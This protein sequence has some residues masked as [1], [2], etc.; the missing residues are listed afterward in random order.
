MWSLERPWPPAPRPLLADTPV[1][2]LGALAASL[3]IA[4]LLTRLAALPPAAVG[5]VGIAAG[6]GAL[7]ATALTWDGATDPRPRA[8]LPPG[9]LAVILLALSAGLAAAHPLGALAYLGIPAWLAGRVARGRLRSLGLAGLPDARAV[10]TGAGVGAVLGA[11][12]L[13]SASGTLGHRPHLEAGTLLPALAYDLGANVISAELFFR[14]ALFN[15]AQ[16]RWSFG[17]AASLATAACVVR[18]LVDPLLPKTPEMALGAAFY[19]ALLSVAN[20][21]LLWRWGSLVPGLLSSLVFFSA[22]RTLASGGAR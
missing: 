9:V 4:G 1:G 21:W 13:V 6:H 18:Y 5:V 8:R 2:L 19:V 14:G 12:L 16:R 22:Y 20:C 15:R 10:L 3:A 7:L 11:H 17:A